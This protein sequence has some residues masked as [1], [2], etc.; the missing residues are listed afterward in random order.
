VRNSTSVPSSC[1]ADL[2]GFEVL[3]GD[4]L[5]DGGAASII[6]EDTILLTRLE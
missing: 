2:L 1:L 4:T 6:Y 5:K 3:V